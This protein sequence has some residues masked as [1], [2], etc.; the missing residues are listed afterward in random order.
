VPVVAEVI[1]K[2]NQVIPTPVLNEKLGGVAFG[3]PYT[4]ER[5]RQ[6][7]ENS[8]RPLYDARGRIRVTFPKVSAQPA[9]ADVKGLVVT[10]EVQEGE[11]YSLG[12]VKIEGAPAD[13]LKVAKIRT[14]DVANF[15]EVNEGVSRVRKELARTGY[16]KPQIQ[17]ERSLQDEK[18]I[19]DVTLH[20][21][22]GPRY[23]FGKLTIEGLDIISEPAVRRIWAAKPGDPYNSEYPDQVLKRIR[24]TRMFDNL[25]KTGATVRI[26]DETRTVDVTL[27]FAGEAPPP[28]PARP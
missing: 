13:I 18:K 23:E 8:V 14:G 17:V 28:K 12:D 15:D 26:N 21:D 1:F 27:K 22:R 10:V 24:E 6:F 16:L 2:G 3:L 20:V 4:E 19:V 7:L 11:S 25:G 5:F 9:K